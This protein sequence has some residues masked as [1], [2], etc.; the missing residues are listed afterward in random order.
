MQN[1]C[2]YNYTEPC[3]IMHFMIFLT[4]Y[5]YARLCI[6]IQVGPAKQK[7][8]PARATSARKSLISHKPSEAG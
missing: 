3:I 7:L 4:M 1:S 8:E 5:V 2:M 6:K